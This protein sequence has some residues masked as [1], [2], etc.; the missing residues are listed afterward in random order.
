[1]PRVNLSGSEIPIFMCIC[2]LF[3]HVMLIFTC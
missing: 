3:L 2:F 1:M